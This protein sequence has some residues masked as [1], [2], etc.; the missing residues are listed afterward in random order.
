MRFSRRGL[1]LLVLGLMLAPQ[2]IAQSHERLTGKRLRAF[3]KS[4]GK[5]ELGRCIAVELKAKRFADE[6]WE[7]VAG[8]RGHVGLEEKGVTYVVREGDPALAQTVRKAKRDPGGKVLLK[9]RVVVLPG[10]ERR[11]VVRIA[12]LQKL[13]GGKRPKK[14]RATGPDADRAV[15]EEQ[16]KGAPAA[17]DRSPGNHGVALRNLQDRA[18]IG[19]DGPGPT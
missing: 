1:L 7:R 6:D 19:A 14:K 10:E 2:T 11:Y 15:L 8:L 16:R 13:G 17:A 9:G 5:S 3:E 12:S 18:N 4:G